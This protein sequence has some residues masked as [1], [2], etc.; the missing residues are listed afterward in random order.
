MKEHKESELMILIH[1]NKISIGL[2]DNNSGYSSAQCN[3]VN[4]CPGS[5]NNCN[6]NNVWSGDEYNSSNAYNYYLNSG[7]WNRNWN[8]RTNAFSVRC[9]TDFLEKVCR[10][11]EAR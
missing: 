1:D 8:N 2:C 7:S 10:S 4:R 6:P 11:G 5:N 3:N 9:V